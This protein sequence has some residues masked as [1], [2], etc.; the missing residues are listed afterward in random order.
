MFG[1]SEPGGEQASSRSD[2]F[3]LY[4]SPTFAPVWVLVMQLCSQEGKQGIHTEH[5]MHLHVHTHSGT[6]S[7]IESLQMYSRLT[8]I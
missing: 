4:Y 7:Q 5:V 8:L 1:E 3:S 6:P 2:F